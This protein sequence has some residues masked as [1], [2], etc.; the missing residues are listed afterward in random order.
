[1]DRIRTPRCRGSFGL[2]GVPHSSIRIL[3]GLPRVTPEWSRSSV[4]WSAPFRCSPCSDLADHVATCS[5]KR[6]EP[7]RFGSPP[8]GRQQGHTWSQQGRSRSSVSAL[9]ALIA[10]AF[11]ISAIP[12]IPRPPPRSSHFIPVDPNGTQYLGLRRTLTTTYIFGLENFLIVKE[13]RHVSP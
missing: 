12:A 8:M 6:R 2:P 3:K 7:R 10:L 9:R 4:V 5:G 11:P 1:M 13:Q